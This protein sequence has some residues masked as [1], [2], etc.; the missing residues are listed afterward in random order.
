MVKA[1]GSAYIGGMS[2]P[3][4]AEPPGAP[5][6][7]AAASADA[8]IPVPP[9]GLPLGPWRLLQPIGRG[10]MGAVW[11]GHRL[12]QDR[13]VAIKLVV[14]RSNAEPWAR[15]SFLNEVRAAAGLNHPGVVA[16]LDHGEVD[17]VAS[18]ASGGQWPVGSPFL[19]MEFVDGRPLH[20]LVG[21]LPWAQ[22]KDVLEQL[23]AALAHSHARRV[24]HRDIKPGNV[25]VRSVASGPRA[26]G[27]HVQLTDFGL[28]RMSSEDSG[29]ERTIAGTPAYMAPEQLRGN[30]R[31]QDTWTDL[32]SVGCLAWALCAGAP[33]FGRRRPLDEFLADHAHRPP[34][35]LVPMM[36]VPA[37][38][39]GWLRRLLCKRPFDRY[40]TAADALDALRHLP[41]EGPVLSSPVPPVRGEDDL[42]VDD[43]LSGDPAPWGPAAAGLGDAQTGGAVRRL[44]DSTFDLP[45]EG[46]SAELSAEPE[47]PARPLAPRTRAPFP[48]RWEGDLTALRGPSSAE[49]IRLF[50]LRR[51][52]LFGRAPLRSALIEAWRRAVEGQRPV[53]LVLRGP[54]GCGKG[55]LTAE[56][57][58]RAHEQSGYWSL[59]VR[60]DPEGLGG[61]ARAL[62][63]RTGCA[64][65]SEDDVAERLR[66]QGLA[67]SPEAARA[68]AQLLSPRAPGEADAPQMGVFERPGEALE[69]LLSALVELDP[70]APT[71]GSAEAS[72]RPGLLWLDEPE[73]EPALIEAALQLLAPPRRPAPLLCVVTLRDEAPESPRAQALVERLLAHPEVAVHAVGPLSREEHE[74]LVRHL[75][76]DDEALVHEVTRRTAG[77]PLFA[78]QLI[79]DWLGRGILEEAP[80]GWRLLRGLPVELPDS[81]HEVWRPRLER[82]I[83]ELAGGEPRR[84]ELIGRALELAAVLGEQVDHPTWRAVC[85]RARTKPEAAIVEALIAQRLAALSEGGWRFTQPLLRETLQR[86]ARE[87][88]RAVAHHR[89]CATALE[90]AAAGG[91]SDR[92]AGHLLAAGDD[93]EALPYLL[94][95]AED[96]L[97]R[98]D[99]AECERLLDRRVAAMDRAAVP[100]ADGLRSLDVGL[101]L[102]LLRRRGRFEDGAARAEAAADLAAARGWTQAHVQALLESAVVQ[103]LLGRPGRAWRRLRQAEA[104]L[105]GLDDRLLRARCFTEQGRLL[106]EAGRLGEARGVLESVRG[107]LRGGSRL[108]DLATVEQLLS[109]VARQSG[110]LEPAQAHALQSL[111]AFERAG[112]RWGVASCH[113]ELGEIA[114]ENGALDAAEQAYREAL[115]RMDALGA[116]DARVVR[117]NLGILLQERRRYQEARPVLLDALAGTAAAGQRAIHAV[118]QLLLLSAAAAEGAWQEWDERAAVAAALLADTGFVDVDVARALERAARLAREVGQRA[119]AEV[120]LRAAVG[121]WR[122][123]GREAEAAAI[124]GQL[125]AAEPTLP[126]G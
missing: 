123:L 30:L 109:R 8:P 32:Y 68:L 74:A 45:L 35:P 75:I 1:R 53:V 60:P 82:L 14:G 48:Q 61:L 67:E 69:L 55:R 24:V 58:E 90:L 52:P 56:L 86:R 91:L 64:G 100:E 12:H 44:D 102:Q 15:A 125:G 105:E 99:L 2:N 94:R 17:A 57:G 120:A 6:P 10:A 42:S 13:P 70:P 118:V 96:R 5:S 80:R 40:T 66:R 92:V 38:F 84:A 7:V 117:I 33:P 85:A 27:L 51:A 126:V 46:E 31:D 21:R 20:D 47:S 108:V 114:R 101:R 107:E 59:R 62:C 121:Q 37:S 41:D 115:R 112:H 89:A 72:A 26:G 28:A 79:V 9:G 93:R 103:Q 73:G 34:P 39:E 104:A 111:A 106:L 16:V 19:V 22:L 71:R 4:E 76:G 119:R 23:L 122:A 3:S 95:A 83:E 49:A 25:L 98:G 78:V 29:L 11:R 88:G 63:E 43:L 113:N 54:E 87:A 110:A 36:S 124:E 81:L 65:L 50:G 97:S 18:A 77:N 116:E